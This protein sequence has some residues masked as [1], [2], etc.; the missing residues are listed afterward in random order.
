MNI[1][2][3]ALS[4]STREHK[5]F[6]ED[7]L[8]EFQNN[9][10]QIYVACANEKRSTEKDGIEISDEMEILRI[11]TGNI[12]GSVSII[13]KGLSTISV[14]ALFKKAVCKNWGN[15]KFDLIIYPTPPITLVNTIEY[16]KK[17]TGAKTYL[18]LK[19]IFPQNAVDLGM[20]SKTGVKSFIYKYFRAKEKRLYHISDYIGCMSP[21]NCEY[22]IKHNPE[23]DKDKL[24]VCPNCVVP[25]EKKII[26]KDLV[27]V[28]TKYG[29]PTDKKV[30]VY[31]GNLG[32]PQGVNFVLECLEKCKDINDAFFLIVGGGT[33]VGKIKTTIDNKK[34]NNA[35][36]IETLPKQDYQ[37]L[38]NSSDVGLIFLDYRFTIPNF[39]S[40]LLSTLQA[41]IP[42]IVASDPATDMGDIV[43][44]NG[45]GWKCMSNDS[46]AFVDCVNKALVA[47]LKTMGEKGHSYLMEN[48][49]VQRGH[50]IIMK[51]MDML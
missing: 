14:D 5:S 13:E 19:D 30:F 15:I 7:L 25:N 20:M 51:H 40:R 24:E 31:G 28:R 43:V 36:Y 18:L 3:L 45:F 27:V 12:T 2:F 38:A 21:A 10:D 22:V 42:V 6:Y 17:K 11:R 1:L 47:D 4:F 29:I 35:K 8:R 49:T 37:L 39:P 48:Y 41:S 26:E 50:D 33:E 46:D 44:N 34:I 16:V 23:I 9:G 32:K